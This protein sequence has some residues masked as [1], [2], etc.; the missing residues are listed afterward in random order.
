LAFTG[1]CFTAGA[2]FF[3]A[4]LVGLL[5]A[6]CFGGAGRFFMTD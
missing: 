4:G 6:F 1:N 2:T 5:A 3:P